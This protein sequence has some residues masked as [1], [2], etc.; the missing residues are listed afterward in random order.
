MSSF[1]GD[2]L[3]VPNVTWSDAI[4]R[5]LIELWQVE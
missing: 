5:D 3:N 4:F 1:W 2:T